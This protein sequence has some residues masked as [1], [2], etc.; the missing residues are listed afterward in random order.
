MRSLNEKDVS[1]AGASSERRLDGGDGG[2]AGDGE[3]WGDASLT[4]EPRCRPY[5]S[6]DSDGWLP[7]DMPSDSAVGE[8]QLSESPKPIQSSP[9]TG[10]VTSNRTP[11][12]SAHDS[13]PVMST[14]L[15]AHTTTS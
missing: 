2:D 1:A 14:I 10:G 13:G 7:S 15:V 4:A 5:A 6:G 3:S 8:M 11:S 12:D 9:A